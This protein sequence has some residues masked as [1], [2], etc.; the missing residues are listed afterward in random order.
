[1]YLLAAVGVIAALLHTA[2]TGL[3]RAHWSRG[4]AVGNVAAVL[5]MSHVL[6][7]ALGRGE[8]RPYLQAFMEQLRQGGAWAWP[9]GTLAFVLLA[10]YPCA[11]IVGMNM[12]YASFTAGGSRYRQ[13]VDGSA[14]ATPS[15][16]AA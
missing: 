7:L 4:F 6:F 3:L 10:G 15:A 12:R 8:D 1:M 11:L 2:S 14:S 16:G 13:A 9:T 5:A